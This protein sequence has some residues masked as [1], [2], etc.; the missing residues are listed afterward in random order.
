MDGNVRWSTDIH[1]IDVQYSQ[2]SFVG[3]IGGQPHAEAKM[4]W[5]VA[6]VLDMSTGLFRLK[7]RT[8]SRTT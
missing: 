3:Q 6:Q 4:I 1:L 2:L 8:R 7:V 5:N